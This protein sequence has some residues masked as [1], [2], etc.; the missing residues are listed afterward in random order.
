MSLKRIV[1]YIKSWE[2]EETFSVNFY[3]KN[4]YHESAFRFPV[5]T[6]II[7]APYIGHDDAETRVILP[8]RTAAEMH[9]TLKCKHCKIGNIA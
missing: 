9:Q 5:G 1:N 7:R 2:I 4:C 6:N 8:N 3:C